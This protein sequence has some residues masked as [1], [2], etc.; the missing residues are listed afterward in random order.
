[1]KRLLLPIL[2]GTLLGL[3][4]AMLWLGPTWW[5]DPEHY[6]ARITAA[7]AETLGRPVEIEGRVS[8][9]LL[10]RPRLTMR[11]VRLTGEPSALLEV[12]AVEATLEPLALLDGRAAVTRLELD[13]PVLAAAT[14]AEEAAGWAR[15][16]AAGLGLQQIVVR[17]GVVVRRDEDRSPL[18]TGLQAEIEAAAGPGGGGP[19]GAL[20]PARKR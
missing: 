6:R 1:M 4:L 13:H 5:F 11:G 17:E 3:G 16:G 12:A 19:G 2:L 7:L 20:T 9:D 15:R 14:L 8:F 18:L 10:P